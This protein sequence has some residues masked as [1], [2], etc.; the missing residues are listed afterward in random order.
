M[1][2]TSGRLN[3]GGDDE[4]ERLLQA[5]YDLWMDAIGDCWPLD[6]A[7]FDAY[8][9]DSKVLMDGSRALGLVLYERTSER[10]SIQAIVVHP[11]ARRQGIGE[12]LLRNALDHITRR[13]RGRRS[14]PPPPYV[15]L[16]GGYR[17][18]W[19]GIPDDLAGSRA[20]FDAVLGWPFSE[21]S[22]DMTMSLDGYTPSPEVFARPDASAIAF[23]LASADDMPNVLTFGERHFPIWLRYFREHAPEDIVIGVQGDGKTIVAS[24]VLDMPPIVWSRLLGDRAAEIGAVGVSRGHRNLGIG[25]ALVARACEILRDRGVEVAVLRWLYRVEFYRRIGF[26]VWKQY[27]MSSTTLEER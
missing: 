23:R 25:T 10:G 21:P 6:R 2:P 11:D 27:A 13:G 19:P 16:G 3:A 12:A 7:A 4:S 5:A 1:S 14:P 26:R 17:Y 22:Y 18:L 20:F 24:L 9:E 15:T 8:A